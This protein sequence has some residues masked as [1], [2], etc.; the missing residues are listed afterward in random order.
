M[1][2]QRVHETMEAVVSSWSVCN[3]RVKNSGK[4]KTQGKS[5]VETQTETNIRRWLLCDFS[6]AVVMLW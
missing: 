1:A 3:L 6:S 5:G 2:L 4:E